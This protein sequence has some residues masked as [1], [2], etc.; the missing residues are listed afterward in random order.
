MRTHLPAHLEGSHVPPCWAKGRYRYTSSRGRASIP[1][2]PLCDVLHVDVHA[3]PTKASFVC[4]NGDSADARCAVRGA[5]HG[6]RAFV[7][8]PWEGAGAAQQVEAPPPSEL[9][10][11]AG[12]VLKLSVEART[13]HSTSKVS[14]RH[15]RTIHP[16]S[17]SQLR[18]TPPP[19]DPLHPHPAIHDQ[20]GVKRM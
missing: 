20:R 12:G 14:A 7:W 10:K 11:F 9:I 5:S 2:R 1:A 16:S 15:S 6:Q 17:P 19:C 3:G 8:S 4:G 13:F 18:S